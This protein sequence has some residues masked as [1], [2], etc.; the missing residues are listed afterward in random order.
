MHISAL[1]I[2]NFRRLK[3][4]LLDLA[5]DISIL[6]GANNSGKTSAAHALQLFVNQSGEK[7]SNSRLQF[8]VLGGN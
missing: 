3:N 1:R 7:F 6:V 2:N 4:V 5:E 8:R